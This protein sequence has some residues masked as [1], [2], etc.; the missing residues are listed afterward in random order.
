MKLQ[1]GSNGNPTLQG[2]PGPGLDS[3]YDPGTGDGDGYDPG[4]GGGF[5][6]GEDEDEGEVQ[7]APGGLAAVLVGLGILTIMAVGSMRR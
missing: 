2:V 6:E 7:T 4:P 1:G 3:G 5:D